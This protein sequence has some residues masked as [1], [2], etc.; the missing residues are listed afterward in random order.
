MIYS[1]IDS[2]AARVK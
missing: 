2:F 1:W